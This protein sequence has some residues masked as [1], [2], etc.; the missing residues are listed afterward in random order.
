VARRCSSAHAPAS[1]DTTLC[2][3]SSRCSSHKWPSSSALPARNSGAA[4]ENVMDDHHVM[5]G[6][7]G[8][9]T[10]A[11]GCAM[12]GGTGVGGQMWAAPAGPPGCV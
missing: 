8:R 2:D 11:A 12:A 3:A 10:G 1:A 7:G 5:R 6:G 9:G 4:H